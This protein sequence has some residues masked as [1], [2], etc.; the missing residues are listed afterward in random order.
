[1][2]HQFNYNLNP[3]KIIPVLLFSSIFETCSVSM[4]GPQFPHFVFKR[5]ASNNTSKTKQMN[6]AKHAQQCTL[7]NEQ[8]KWEKKNLHNS[9]IQRYKCQIS[10]SMVV[11]LFFLSHY[12]FLPSKSAFPKSYSTL[13]SKSFPNNNISQQA[14]SSPTLRN[15]FPP[16]FHFLLERTQ[17]ARHQARRARPCQ[18]LQKR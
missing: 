15:S 10:Q 18:S 7:Y 1:M 4:L 11:S 12:C 8:C 9:N 5:N 17:S 16:R 6:W 2:C 13:F 3:M 14:P